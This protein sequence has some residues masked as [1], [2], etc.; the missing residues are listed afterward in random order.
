MLGWGSL[1]RLASLHLPTSRLLLIVD[2]T[3]VVEAPSRRA[4]L[5]LNVA[6][7]LRAARLVLVDGETLTFN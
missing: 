4:G 1:L 7:A 5:L 6:G 2:R 3:R